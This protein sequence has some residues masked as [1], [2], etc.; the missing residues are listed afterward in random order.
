MIKDL[1]QNKLYETKI[2]MSLKK[3]I[4]KNDPADPI[5]LQF[6][7]N[8]QETNISPCEINDP[9]GDDHYLKVKG[10]VHRY[11]D[12]VLLIPAS[13]CMVLCRFCFRRERVS[14]AT[15]NLTEKELDEALAYVKSN[16]SIREVIITGGEP[17]AVPGNILAKVM[18]NLDSIAH[19]D[20]IRIHTRLPIVAPENITEKK[21]GLLKVKK[22]VFVVI[23]C[24]HH[25]ELTQE[26][27]KCLDSFAEAGMPLLSQSVLLKGVNDTAEI[28]EN[29]FRKLVRLRV[30]PY[31]LHH[32]DLV[33]GTGHFR[34]DIKKGQAL[35]KALR[36]RVSGICLPMYIF[37]IPSG[38]GKVPIGPCY[39]EE[40]E[41]GVTYVRDYKGNQHEYPPQNKRT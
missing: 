15:T 38:F 34:V 18:N 36:G 33:K 7:A 11:P 30:K 2:T 31:Y 29:L 17:L 16:P 35:M 22:P 3:L 10:I 20:V 24:N 40:S 21:L 5:A 4:D 8:K 37:D 9:I 32:C 14:S 39:F 28:L 27:G 6:T 1:P 19:V 26:V 23:H 12:R 13:D 41:D 25:R